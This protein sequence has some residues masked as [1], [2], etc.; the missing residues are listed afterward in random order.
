VK[1]E[2]SAYK[3]LHCV[4]TKNNIDVISRFGLQTC[5]EEGR[6]ATGSSFAFHLRNEVNHEKLEAVC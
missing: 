6:H 5:L 4:T 3:I 2:A 1:I